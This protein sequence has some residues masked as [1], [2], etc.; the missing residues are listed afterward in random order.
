MFLQIG[1]GG[2]P[3]IFSQ[4]VKHP[5]KHKHPNDPGSRQHPDDHQDDKNL[6][7]KGSGLAH[8]FPETIA[9]FLPLP[10]YLGWTLRV[11]GDSFK[12]ARSG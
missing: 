4:P 3:V 9:R 2:R 11:G 5:R 10:S 6:G 7:G 8:F 12:S 1:G